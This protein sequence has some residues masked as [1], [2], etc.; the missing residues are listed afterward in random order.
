MGSV[1]AGHKFDDNTEF[2]KLGLFGMTN[3]ISNSVTPP[4]SKW[5]IGIYYLVPSGIAAVVLVL[6]QVGWLKF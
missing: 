6:W 3:A 5:M 4:S 1:D 2:R